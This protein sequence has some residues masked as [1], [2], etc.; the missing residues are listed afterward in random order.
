MRMCVAR[1]SRY[2]PA[3]NDDVPDRPLRR[4]LRGSS[5]HATH[6]RAVGG[7]A[8]GP[9]PRVPVAHRSWTD[10]RR[11]RPAR[12]PPAGGP[13]A[14][15]IR[16]EVARRHR[17]RRQRRQ[18][19]RPAAPR[20][21][22]S[23]RVRPALGRVRHGVHGV[24]AGGDDRR[25][26]GRHRDRRQGHHANDPAR[27]HRRARSAA[28]VRRRSRHRRR[29]TQ[30]ACGRCQPARRDYGQIPNP[31]AAAPPPIRGHRDPVAV[32]P[33]PRTRRDPPRAGNLRPAGGRLPAAAH[34]RGVHVHDLRV[35]PDGDARGP[36][37]VRRPDRGLRRVHH[38]GRGP[39]RRAG[40]IRRTSAAAGRPRTRLDA[41]HRT[42]P[43]PATRCGA[44]TAVVGRRLR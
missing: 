42:A 39:R 32:A 36:H 17:G 12:S 44:R 34:H 40:P 10:H 22:R 23:P 15:H 4:H 31:A 27:R 9:R 1:P 24:G 8:R 43:A 25:H 11:R 35:G 3:A 14:R 20:S 5:R 41:R 13:A 7:A 21:D 16:R 38:R 33:G 2:G 18:H 28:R 26:H 19:A 37:P 30:P 29:V 6:R